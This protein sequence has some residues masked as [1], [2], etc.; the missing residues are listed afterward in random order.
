MSDSVLNTEQK[1]AVSELINREANLLDRREWDDWLD[2][3]TEDAVFWAPSWKDEE[4]T[5]D[6]PETQLNLLFLEG[7]GK[8]EDRV[9]RIESRDSYASLPLD[10]T[11]HLVG[12]VTIEKTSEE[13]ITVFAS[14]LIHSFG[15]HGSKTNG[16]LYDYVLRRDGDGLKIARKKVT[17]I[18]DRIA[19]PIDVYHL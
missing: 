5:V 4:E 6:Q 10:R 1:L 11:V 15:K 14:C 3:Y 19:G 2:L 16:C 18:D 7:R 17:L 12:N 9:F 13:E 8:L